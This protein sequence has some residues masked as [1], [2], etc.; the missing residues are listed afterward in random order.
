LNYLSLFKSKEI[1]EASDGR[2]IPCDYINH[3]R[4]ELDCN[5]CLGLHYVFIRYTQDC[6]Y[7]KGYTL[8]KTIHHLLDFTVI[9]ESK[10]VKDLHPTSLLNINTEFFYSFYLY[11]QEIQAPKEMATRLK[12]SLV[13]VAA[14]NDHGMPLLMLPILHESGS[15]PR[16][17]ISEGCFDELSLALREHIDKLYEKLEYRKL[18]EQSEP[19]NIS[20][21]RKLISEHQKKGRIGYWE[22]SNKRALKTLLYHKHPFSVPFEEYLSAAFKDFNSSNVLHELYGRY[23]NPQLRFTDKKAGRLIYYLESLVESYFPTPTDQVAIVLFIMIQTGWNKET[24]FAIDKD[25]FEHVLTSALSTNQVL[26]ISEKERGQS[27]DKPFFDP[28]CFKSASDKKDKYST[29][30]LI[31]LAKA[32][33]EPFIGLP[34]DSTSN[35]DRTNHNYLFSCMRFC[36]QWSATNTKQGGRPGRYSTLAVKSLW[37]V[38]IKRFFEKY[39][40]FDNGKKITKAQDLNGRLRPTW[41]KYVRDKRKHPLSLISMEQGHSSIE[42][43]DVHYDNSS[44]ANQNRRERLKG[45]LDLLTKSLRERKFKGLLYNRNTTSI[46]KTPLN[47]FTIPGHK[48]SLW[49]CMNS[50]KADWP[51]SDK[52]LMSGQKCNAIAKCLFCSQICIFEDSLPYLMEREHIIQSQLLTSEDGITDPLLHDELEI[53]QYIFDEW[54]NEKALKNAARFHRKNNNLLPNDMRSLSMFFE[55]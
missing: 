47:F 33:S 36:Q 9:F 30:N 37:T 16:E 12:S 54:G 21:I 45:E 31:H 43:T 48:K 51:G 46:D 53:I 19:Y 35:M 44:A 22:P 49:G 40:V 14:Q 20:D 8:R 6:T 25:N 39:E 11:L 1:A 2:H 15:K 5:Y 26:I 42:T 23:L 55:D 28:K 41:I 29:Y 18:V 24:V 34:E 50:K 32:L 4:F 10:N 27:I 17:P 7:S 13:K 52:W 38:G 3:K